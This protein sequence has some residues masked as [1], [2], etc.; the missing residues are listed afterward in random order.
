M[1]NELAL[2]PC[3]G[4]GDM[5]THLS[6]EHG[7]EIAECQ[8]CDIRM[9]AITFGVLCAKWNHIMGYVTKK[10]PVGPLGNT[11]PASAT[12]VEV[13][14]GMAPIAALNALAADWDDKAQSLYVA[15]EKERD[16]ETAKTQRVMKAVYRQAAED[17]RAALAAGFGNGRRDAVTDLE[18]CPECLTHKGFGHHQ[19]CSQRDKP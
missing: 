11:R 16:A 6:N 10:A 12:A 19:T 17:L 13:T 7:P 3:R 4:C 18:R 2:K 14:E 5:P 9:E 1:S 8:L 15:S